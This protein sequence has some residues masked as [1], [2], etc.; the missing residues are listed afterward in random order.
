MGNC[1]VKVATAQVSVSIKTF[2]PGTNNICIPNYTLFRN[3]GRALKRP[4]VKKLHKIH[5]LFP[6]LSI[7]IKTK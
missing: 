5:L 6:R 1:F 3:V 2:D 4:K 7:T